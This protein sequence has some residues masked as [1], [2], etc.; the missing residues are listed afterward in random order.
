M[1]IW[2]Q[3]SRTV[4]GLV[5]GMVHGVVHGDVVVLVFGDDVSD[6]WWGWD[7]PT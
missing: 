2:G 7:N 1:A 6:V 4:H 3:A 5:H